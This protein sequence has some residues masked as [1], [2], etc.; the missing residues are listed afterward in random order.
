M[1]SL[2]AQSTGSIQEMRSILS[3]G[4]LFDGFMSHLLDE[5][6]SEA[7]PSVIEFIQF[8]DRIRIENADRFEFHCLYQIVLP[9]TVPDSAI[10]H[11]HVPNGF[12]RSL[13]SDYQSIALELMD[14]YVR[15]GADFQINLSHDIRSGYTHD[16]IDGMDIEEL[17]HLFDSCIDSMI[18]LMRPAF[19]RFMKS[20]NFA[21]IA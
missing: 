2:S 18:R 6:C 21:L 13:V 1:Q 20:D 7:L 16:V 3:N 11:G 14:K 5:Y 19:V 15:V 10:V 4:D 12:D 9:E 17:F 8:K